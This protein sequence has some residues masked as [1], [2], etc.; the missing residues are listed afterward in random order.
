[1]GDAMCRALTAIHSAGLVHQD[2]KAGNVMRE[3]SGRLVLMDLGASTGAADQPRYGTPAYM[4]P[5]VAAGGTASPGSDVYSL[6]VLLFHL[7]TGRFPYGQATSV[8]SR[9]QGSV[10]AQLLADF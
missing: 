2:V 8:Q 1:V 5:E 6:G 10:G 4:A 3:P 7:L 9:G